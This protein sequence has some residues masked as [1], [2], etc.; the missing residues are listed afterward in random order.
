MDVGHI[1]PI[2]NGLRGNYNIDV[3][4]DKHIIIILGET[5]RQDFLRADISFS[6][7][8]FNESIINIDEKN[9][10]VLTSQ[11]TYQAGTYN[12]FING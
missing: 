12:V 8:L 10:I 7:I 4:E 2:T 3:P 9:Y 6:E 11:D 1:A 5:L